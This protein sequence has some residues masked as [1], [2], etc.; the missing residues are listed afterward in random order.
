MVLGE[1]GAGKT[2]TL[3]KLAESLLTRTFEDLSQPLPVVLNLSSWAS[4]RKDID[5]W[6]AQELYDTYKVSKSLGKA[7]INEEQLILLLDGLDEV[8]PKYRNA[9]VQALNKFFQAHGRTEIVV[10][11]RIRDYEALSNKLSLRSAIY[12][13]PL[14][15]QQIDE[16]LEQTGESLVALRSIINQNSEIKAFASS[17]LILSIMSLAYQSCDLENFPQSATSEVF[18]QRLFDAYIKR[19]FQRR[20]TNK[21]YRQEQ[22]TRW[23]I[24]LAQQMVQKSQTIFLID[25]LQSNCFQERQYLFRYRLL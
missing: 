11:S 3:L 12:V 17:P 25:K 15:S 20:I 4:K 24:W 8:E 16:Y 13:Q 10:C 7:W 6:L 18:R 19:M 23:L 22:A 9:C 1:P 14:T 21:H 2:I 5:D